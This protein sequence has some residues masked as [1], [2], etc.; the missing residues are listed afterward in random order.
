[1]S[2]GGSPDQRT[3]EG[4][5]FDAYTIKGEKNEVYSPKFLYHGMQY[6]SVNLTWT[7]SALDMTASVIRAANEQVLSVST[8]NNLFNSIHKIIDRSIQVCV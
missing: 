8:S 7:P 6:V 3:T 2:E 4:P 1:M 5:I